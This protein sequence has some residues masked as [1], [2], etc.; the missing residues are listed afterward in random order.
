MKA[1]DP[2][3]IATCFKRPI[4]FSQVLPVN[5]VPNLRGLETW[6]L[7]QYSLTECRY[8]VIMN[9]KLIN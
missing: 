2:L 7:E 8:E 3:G 9:N 1:I 5:N 6:N 4:F